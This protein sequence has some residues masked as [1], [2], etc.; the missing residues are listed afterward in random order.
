M[1]HSYCTVSSIACSVI[2]VETNLVWAL[3]QSWKASLLYLEEDVFYDL[4]NEK[5]ITGTS[6]HDYCQLN[7][8]C[9]DSL[10]H[11]RVSWLR[12]V[13]SQETWGDMNHQDGGLTDGDF[14]ECVWWGGGGGWL[15]VTFFFPRS[16]GRR[17]G[18]GACWECVT[19]HRCDLRSVTN[20]AFVDRSR[21]WKIKAPQ[22]IALF[23]LLLFISI[24][25]KV[26]HLQRCNRILLEK[27][28]DSW[29]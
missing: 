3:K 9:T 1:Q 26:A 22:P 10:T 29:K 5:C 13:H 25:L 4:M 17:A 18:T 7:R 2:S 19:W 15:T 27:Y 23:F 20:F 6:P 28:I 24:M 11:S 8:H 12:P 16:R 14:A 21:H